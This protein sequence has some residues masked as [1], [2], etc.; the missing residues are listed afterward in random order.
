MQ[1]DYYNYPDKSTLEDARKLSE[2]VTYP[3]PADGGGV[4]DVT[5]GPKILIN[6]HEPRSEEGGVSHSEKI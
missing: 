4:H 1:H 5:N 3:S 6:D 2:W